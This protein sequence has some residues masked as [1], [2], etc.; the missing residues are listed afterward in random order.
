MAGM[1]KRAAAAVLFLASA[2]CVSPDAAAPARAS[3]PDYGLDTNWLCRPGR[4]D[5]CGQDLS[6]I[7]LAADGTMTRE[8]FARAADPGIDCFYVYPTVSLDPGGNSDLVA[9]AEER[10]VAHWQFARF[11]AHCRTFAPMYRQT[12]LASLRA[13]MTGGE[14]GGT[15]RALAYDDVLAAW[16]HYLAH[17]N[18]GR[19]VVL[20]GHSQGMAILLRLIKNEIDGKPLQRQLVS[21]I[22]LGGNVVVP[23]GADVGASLQHIPPCRAASQTGCVVSYVSFRADAPPPQGG[24]FGGANEPLTT[25][26][27]PG[28]HALCTNPADLGGGPAQL[29]SYFPTAFE[30]WA[31]GFRWTGAGEEI[32][33]PFVTTPGL[34]SAECV[35]DGVMRYLAVTVHAAPGDKRAHDIPGDVVVGGRRFND[36][37][38]HR[39]DVAIA[40]GDL[41]DLVGRQSAAYLAE[42]QGGGE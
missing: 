1:L 14:G 16:R 31:P 29:R 12:T 8:P 17:D 38:L 42:G 26:V 25:E 3:A 5:A 32:D 37:G 34:L 13:R 4:D 22:L 41:V 6:A 19:G 39:V 11:G 10:S 30:Q 20:V 27:A 7:V 23:D 40:L 24:Y 18:N 2:A 9:G 28:A 33:A 21:A 35:T 36:W 15:D